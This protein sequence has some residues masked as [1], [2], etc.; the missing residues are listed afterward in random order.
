MCALRSP[1]I[2]GSIQNLIICVKTALS[3][4]LDCGVNI[5][6]LRCRN[7]RF[8]FESLPEAFE[9]QSLSNS[10]GKKPSHSVVDECIVVC[11]VRN[12]LHPV[13]NGPRKVG[14]ESLCSMLQL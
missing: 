13:C 6:Q 11:F 5:R 3:K 1:S 12:H 4:H 9:K 8:C 2:M 14:T 7:I 10:Q